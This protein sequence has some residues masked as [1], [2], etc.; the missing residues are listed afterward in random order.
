[1]KFRIVPGMRTDFF[2]DAALLPAGWARDVAVAVRDGVITRVETGAVPAVRPQEVTIALPGLPNLHSH[3]FQR[4][5]A[6]LTE[7]R[8]PRNDS[9]WTWRQLMYRFLAALTPD[10]VEA[11]A[12]FAMMEMLEGGFTALA[13]FHYLHHGPDGKP[14][15]DLAALGERI[16]IAARATGIGLTLLPV[17]YAHGGFGGEPLTEGQRRFANDVERYLRLLE[18][19]RR[20]LAAVDDGKL[21]VAPHS[22]RAVTPQMLDAIHH[23]VPDGPIHIHIA[24]QTKE[25]DECIAWSGRRPVEWLFDRLPVDERWCLIHATH[26]SPQETRR[27]AGSRAVVG[28]CPLTEA[29]LGDG[30][31]PGEAYLQEHG[32]WGVGSDSNVEITAAGELKQFEYSQRLALRARNV[33][34]LDEGRSTGRVLYDGALLGG[35]QALGRRIGAIAVGCRADFVVLDGDHPGFAGAQDDQWLDAYVFA[36][37]KSAIKDVIVGGRCVVTNGRHHDHGAIAERYAKTMRR[38]AAL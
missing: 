18:A 19:T 11:I 1:V 27:I 4:G 30:I 7:R 23:A 31:F 24:E 28:L 15:A 6:G 36:L 9:F 38:L 25:V 16:A 34:A 33:L 14:Y 5:M 17:L 2:F 10:D 35:G 13:E 37:G 26:V 8:G 29:N 12:A 22:L 20:A 32:R 3:T 21:G